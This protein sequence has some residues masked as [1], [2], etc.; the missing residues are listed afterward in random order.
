MQELK[1]IRCDHCGRSI[2]IKQTVY[3][4][5]PEGFMRLCRLCFTKYYSKKIFRTQERTS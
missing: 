1:Q 4:L 3:L 5:K 2:L